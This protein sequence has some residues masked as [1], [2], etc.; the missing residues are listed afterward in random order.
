MLDA[1]T[2]SGKEKIINCQRPSENPVD[3][4][5]YNIWEFHAEAQRRRVSQRSDLNSS[6]W[7]Y[8]HDR[9]AADGRRWTQMDTN[10][11]KD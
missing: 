1:E 11:G 6:D 5:V 9:L 10:R 4:A 2:K 8:N 3:G 7:K